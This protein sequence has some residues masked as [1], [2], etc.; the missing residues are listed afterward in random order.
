MGVN[1]PGLIGIIVFYL[2]IL[3]IGFVA[4]RKKSS[5]SASSNSDDLL[6]AGRNLG[7][8][9]ASFSSAATM[10]GGAYV[11]G[12]A[13][14]MGRDGLVWSLA[15]ILYNV[16]VAIAALIYAPKVRRARYTTIFDPMQE[17]YG[18]NMGGFLFFSEL[19]SDLFWEAAILSALGTTLSIIMDLD[20][21]ISII[22]SACVAVFYTF[23]GGLYSV[24]YTDVIQLLCIAVGLVLS[25][26]FAIKHPSVNLERIQGNWIGELPTRQIGP[27][28]DFLLQT[29]FGGIPWQAFYQRILACKSPNLAR[30]STLVG[31]AISIIMAFPPAVIG[32]IGAATDWNATSY[33]GE[34]PLSREDWVDILPMVLQY[35]CPVAISVIGIGAISAAASDREIVWVLRISIAVTGTLGAIIA[36]TVRSV[37]G[38]FV[39]CGDLM[40]VIQFPMLTCALW[41]KF[42]NTYGSIAGCI[43]GLFINLTGGF[44]TLK[45]P[46][47]IKYPFYDPE[48]GQ[49][50]PFKTLATI[51]CFLTIIIVSYVTHVLFTKEILPK[52]FD[53]FQCYV[54]K[55][56]MTSDLVPGK[57]DEKNGEISVINDKKQ[58]GSYKMS[59][60]A[61]TLNGNSNLHVEF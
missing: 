37:Y 38:L 14:S 25:I 36:I 49:I 6:L 3:I 33:P 28:V 55:Y 32:I 40:Y 18:N 45:I 29:T 13:E 26:P 1:I 7:M 46:P 20:T 9:V 23:F 22:V 17:K 5:K 34:V 48:I 44:P 60:N 54:E 57:I 12:T 8:F 27:Y 59:S 53:I 24:A 19:L 50:F 16:G 4:A 11:N 35:L 52:K 47:L 30:N 41:V 58:N 42:A 10:V 31:V 51:C 2:L 21:S 43:V 61:L 56:H 15:P 39:L